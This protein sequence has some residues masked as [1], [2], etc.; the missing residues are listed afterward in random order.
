MIVELKNHLVEKSELPDTF[1]SR[2]EGTHTI[3]DML[4]TFVK[5]ER[6]CCDF[7]PG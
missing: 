6:P 1:T 2:F 3:I 4:S 7:H 5:T